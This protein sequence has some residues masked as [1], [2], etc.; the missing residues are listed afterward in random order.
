MIVCHC[1][2][3]IRRAVFTRRITF[4]RLFLDQFVVDAP[5]IFIIH[6]HVGFGAGVQ[7]RAPATVG[8]VN[9]EAFTGRFDGALIDLVA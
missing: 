8:E 9:G 1:W 2:L 5:G 4:G 3:L 6:G 7:C